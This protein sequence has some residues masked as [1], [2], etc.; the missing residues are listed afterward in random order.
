MAENETV[1]TVDEAAEPTEFEQEQERLA[2]EAELLAELPA[3]MPQHR[4]RV[5]QKNMLKR[6]MLTFGPVFAALRAT[7]G[8]DGKTDASKLTRD[9]YDQMFDALEAIDE[10]GE[11]IA[12]DK[13]A[14]IA[15]SEGKGDAEMYALY[16]RYTRAQGE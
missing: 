5:R 3:L 10:F 4:L 9:Q 14:Y 12:T 2:A 13:A 11:A 8:E 7:A 15:W 16:G 6:I 1:E